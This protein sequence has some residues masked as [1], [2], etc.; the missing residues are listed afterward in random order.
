[1]VSL[2]AT[3]AVGASGTGL[4]MPRLKIICPVTAEAVDTGITIN[5]ESFAA[6]GDDT[7]FWCP[8]CA[9][10]HRIDEVMGW[11]LGDIEPELE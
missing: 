5:E 2:T 6:L 9:K 10:S 11:L 1:M 8:H 3:H 7:K 4:A